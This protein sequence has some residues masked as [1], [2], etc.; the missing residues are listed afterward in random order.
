WDLIGFDGNEP[1]C[2]RT[3]PGFRRLTGSGGTFT[4]ITAP[5]ENALLRKEE[6]EKTQLLDELTDYQERFLR[7]LQALG[8]EQTLQSADEAYVVAHLM[9]GI[10]GFL[11]WNR[12]VSYLY[13]LEEVLKL[14]SEEKIPLN[15]YTLQI[16]HEAAYQL[17]SFFTASRTQGSFSL[18][19][20]RRSESRL[21]QL[22]W[23][24]S[25][26]DE[27][28][29]LFIGKYHLNAVEH[30]LLSLAKTGSFS[31][32]PESDFTKGAQMPYGALIQFNGDRRGFAGIYLPENTLKEIVHPL[33]TGSREKIENRRALDSLTE[34]GNLIGNQF[35]ENCA[36]T[37]ITLQPSA[38]LTYFGPGEP[39]K[40]LGTPTYCF[41]CE[42]NGYSFYLA[43]DFRL[44]QDI[45]E[46][47]NKEGNYSLPSLFEFLPPVIEQSLAE[48]ELKATISQ[49]P[50][51]SDLIGF[52]GGITSVVS[53]VSED[54]MTPDLVL[55]LSCEMSVVDCL[56][57]S[58]NRM[59]RRLNQEDL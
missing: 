48:Y 31:V 49:E 6:E 46:L 56:L 47:S 9:K 42:I 10:C 38:P 4:P 21:L 11:G 40:A 12:V 45:P 1:G 18:S 58:T 29:H 22:I 5:A 25:R 53:F 17:K 43:G 59:R 35:A 3:H 24:A 30:F 33:I 55:F 36:G 15:D 8:S 34:F 20:L 2:L 26:N 44:P 23:G 39:M 19:T 54:K 32:R 14:L 7:A 51:Q 50:S 27:K 16:L 28:T 13:P 37:G 52:D 57:G 41:Y